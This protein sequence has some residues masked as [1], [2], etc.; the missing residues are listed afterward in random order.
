MN[1]ASLPNSSLID[2]AHYLIVFACQ[3]R[4]NL[5]NFAHTFATFAHVVRDGG[6]PRLDDEQSFS[7]S[8]LPRSLDISFFGAPTIGGNIGLDVTLRW[9]RKRGAQSSAWGPFRIK[10]DLHRRA[11]ERADYLAGGVPQFVVLDGRTRPDRAFNCIHALSDLGLTKELLGTGIAY[12][13][14]A[15]RKVARYLRP[16]FEDD[17]KAHPWVWDTFWREK[18]PVTFRSL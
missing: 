8:W 4:L 11:R 3:R 12:G 15:S 13:N 18:H 5:P 17:A 16:W 9:V 2:D 6:V 7:I 14:R 10:P 1:P